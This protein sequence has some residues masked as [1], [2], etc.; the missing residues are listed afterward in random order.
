MIPKGWGGKDWCYFG[1][2]LEDLLSS[3]VAQ[4]AKVK[5]VAGSE[6]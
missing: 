1:K 2:A 4:H 5:Y 3:D 6:E